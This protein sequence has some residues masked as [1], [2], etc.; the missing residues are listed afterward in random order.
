MQTEA[1]YQATVAAG[2]TQGREMFMALGLHNFSRNTAS[3]AVMWK[4]VG[5]L[6][7]HRRAL[8]A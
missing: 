6:N 8:A 4:A 2:F 7:A 5:E 3:Y 1:A